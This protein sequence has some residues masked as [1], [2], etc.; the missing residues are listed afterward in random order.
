MI[1]IDFATIDDFESFRV[2]DP[3]SKYINPQL[4]RTKIQNSE[5]ILAKE[6]S[7]IWGFLRLNYIWSTRPY[8]EFVFVK[9]DRRGSGIGKQLL[10]FLQEYLKN[11]YAYLFSSTRPYF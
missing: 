7:E 1:N 9:E 2:F 4:I 6:N 5:I 10:Q 11:E 3:H 8:I